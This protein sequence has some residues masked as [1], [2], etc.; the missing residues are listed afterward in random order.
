MTIGTG[1]AIVK[2][3]TQKTLEA[4]G[5]SIANNAM[6][7]ADDADYSVALDGSGAPDVEFAIAVTFGTAPTQ[8][9]LIDL[10]AQ[11]LNI[12]GT[13]DAQA[14]TTT[15]RQKYIGSFVVNNVTTQQ[16]LALLAYDVPPNAAYY[17]HNNGTGQ[18]ISSGWTLK[19]TPRTVGPAA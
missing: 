6:A 7:Q 17:L 9:T 13:S 10:Y 2:Y 5:A 8:N 19:A 14:P 4:S 16:F 3:G 18:T 11:A 15:Y 12:D 1:D